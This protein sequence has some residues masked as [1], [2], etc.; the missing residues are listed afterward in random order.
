MY[1]D[2]GAFSQILIG[3]I[4][5]ASPS[6]EPKYDGLRFA[7][8]NFLSFYSFADQ[9]KLAIQGSSLFSED[10]IFELGF[11]TNIKEEVTLKIG[12]DH[13]EGALQKREIYLYDKL[14]S[15]IT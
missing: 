8:N 7:G 10:H 2:Q 5:G 15:H 14:L 6:F 1:N 4:E 9:Q 13:I 11:T 12:I 3:F